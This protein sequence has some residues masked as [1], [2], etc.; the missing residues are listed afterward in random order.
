MT[1]EEEVGKCPECG[2]TDKG[3]RY[4][5]TP[6]IMDG[7]P[8]ARFCKNAWHDVPPEVRGDEF[9]ELEFQVIFA[10]CWGGA[11]YWRLNNEETAKQL[12]ITEDIVM[13]TMMSISDK[14]GLGPLDLREFAR[15]ALNAELRRRSGR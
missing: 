1:P 5:L 10:L 2:S 11:P 14:A 15:T 7:D 9:T 8:L 12:G 13:Q 6:Q 4:S 3:A